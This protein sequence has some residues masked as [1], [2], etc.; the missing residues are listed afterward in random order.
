[1]RYVSEFDAS[2]V[3]E[4]FTTDND[5]FRI[6]ARGWIG[7]NNDTDDTAAAGQSKLTVLVTM[8]ASFLCEI[9]LQFLGARNAHKKKTCARKHDTCSRS[10]YTS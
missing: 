7:N 4:T 9:E 1:M 5:L 6:T 8:D 10:L 2:L 3:Q